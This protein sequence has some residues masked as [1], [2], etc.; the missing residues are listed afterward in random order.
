M[1]LQLLEDEVG[2]SIQQKIG[3]RV[4]SFC[5]IDLCLA[6]VSFGSVAKLR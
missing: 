5:F 4:V 3:L 1:G 2:V 6:L